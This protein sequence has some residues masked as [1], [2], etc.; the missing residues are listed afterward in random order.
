MELAK[1]GSLAEAILKSKK[2]TADIDYDNTAKQIIL[3]GIARGMMYLYQHHII[4]RDLKPDNI[5]LDQYL[6]PLITDFGLSKIYDPGYSISQS[7][8]CGTSIYMAPEIISGNRY[9]GKADV[10]S[11]G[12]LMYEVITELVPYPLFQEKGKLTIYQ[13]NEK[14]IKE[15]YHIQ[16][17]EDSIYDICESD[18]NENKFYLDG[19]DI[20]ELYAYLDSFTENDFANDNNISSNVFDD[21]KRRLEAVE[22]E[23]KR[24]K[25]DNRQILK[26]IEN[27]E[28]E[29][30]Q[31]K[32]KC[33]NDITSLMDQNEQL[34]KDNEKIMSL[35]HE[36]MREKELSVND[37]D[38]KIEVASSKC[39]VKK[40][41]EAQELITI[42]DFNALPLASQQSVVSTIIKNSESSLLSKFLSTVNPI[43]IKLNNLLSYLMKLKSPS[44][45]SRYF[46]IATNNHSQR[47]DL[48][49][50]EQTT[51]LIFIV[52]SSAVEKL[53]EKSLLNSSDF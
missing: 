1:R 14:V 9:S 17:V 27:I 38:D 5:L 31:I 47:F 42:H 52:L 2:S 13:F 46:S 16:K 20:E 10:Y 35:I 25:N 48:L 18:E 36:L 23:N 37:S 7:Q 26:K 51:N 50:D 33:H 4:H 22:D 39:P 40:D 3:V 11:F 53:Y 21:I 49:K 12:I 30:Q 6:H 32:L 8:T 24:L 41:S 44:D 15:N 28:K 34:K 43:F 29:N 45:D 19:V